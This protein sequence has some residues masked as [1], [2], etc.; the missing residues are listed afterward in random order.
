MAYKRQTVGSF[1][2]PK[3]LTNEEVESGKIQ[4][5][6]YIKI[7]QDITL[8]AGTFLRVENK[9]FQ[10]ASLQKAIE[11]GKLTGDTATKMLERAN[12][13]PEWLLGEVIILSNT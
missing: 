8:K 12:E 1:C 6:P 2:K 5:P 11:S 10:L 9:Q 4:Q 13:M 7:K 3:K